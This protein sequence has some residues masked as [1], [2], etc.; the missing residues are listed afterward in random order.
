[1]ITNPIL[2]MTRLLGRGLRALLDTR[3]WEEVAVRSTM[4]PGTTLP[5]SDT[6]ATQPVR[7]REASWTGDA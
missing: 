2:R 4:P 6:P 1:M 3:I 5:S 7:S